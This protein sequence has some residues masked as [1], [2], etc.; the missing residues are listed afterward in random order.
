MN[1]WAEPGGVTPVRVEPSGRTLAVAPGETVFTAA[2]RA[3]LRWPTTCGGHAECGVCV[4]EVLEAPVALPE[5]DGV[6]S[7][8]LASVPERRLHPDRTH[9]LA[10]RLVPTPGTVV[11]KR[12]VGPAEHGSPAPGG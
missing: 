10:C 11:R 12:G 7:A 9:R 3:G 5:P 6:E 8:R 4:L 1:V 2:V